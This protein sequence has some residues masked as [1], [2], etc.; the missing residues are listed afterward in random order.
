M[1]T[2][3]DIN[4]LENTSKRKRLDQEL[5][6]LHV[7]KKDINIT[8]SL[9][10]VTIPPQNLSTLSD[11][12]DLLNMVKADITHILKIKQYLG[13]FRSRCAHTLNKNPLNFF[14][15]R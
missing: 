12:V 8:A 7:S 11:G 10:G 4:I 9:L 14:L 15:F 3:I 13:R 5:T 1:A 6:L 2:Y